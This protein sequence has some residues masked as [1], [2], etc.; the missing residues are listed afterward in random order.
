MS[1]DCI[2]GQFVPSPMP[3]YRIAILKATLI[4]YRDTTL[5]RPSCTGALYALIPNLAMA[6]ASFT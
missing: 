2:P 4:S 6:I 5:Y 1:P 3:S